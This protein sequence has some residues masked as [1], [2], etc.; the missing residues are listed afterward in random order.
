MDIAAV[1]PLS[2]E[3]GERKSTAFPAVEPR[4][5]LTLDTKDVSSERRASVRCDP[6]QVIVPNGSSALHGSWMGR[7]ENICTS[8]MKESGMDT[9]LT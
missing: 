3:L 7:I 9:S 6:Q 2:W 4:R 5:L 1:D 8:D